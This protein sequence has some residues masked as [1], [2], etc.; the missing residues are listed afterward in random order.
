M[1]RYANTRAFSCHRDL[2]D[3]L[4]RLDRVSEAQ[5]FVDS[6]KHLRSAETVAKQLKALRVPLLHALEAEYANVLGRVC[7]PVDPREFPADVS[8]ALALVPEDRAALLRRMTTHLSDYNQSNFARTWA[9]RRSK[10]VLVSLRKLGP[11]ERPAAGR[12]ERGSHRVGLMARVLLQLLL[13]EASLSNTVLGHVPSARRRQLLANVAEPAVDA[14]LEVLEGAGKLPHAPVLSDQ[15][16][17]RLFPLLDLWFI[18]QALMPR[19][20]ASLMVSLMC[21]LRIHSCVCMY[22]YSH[23]RSLSRCVYAFDGAYSLLCGRVRTASS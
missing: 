2:I 8:A 13:H 21:Y 19:Y 6:H 14:M 5:A 23:R 9:D 10:F 15:V 7:V 22:D 1:P 20:S 18:L 4:E 17:G 3:T 16:A 12:Y 11:E